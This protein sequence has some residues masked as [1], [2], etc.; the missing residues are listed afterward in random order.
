MAVKKDV[1]KEINN[2]TL[3]SVKESTQVVNEIFDVLMD[4]LQAEDEVVISGFGRF[5]LYE[6]QPRPVRNPKTQEEMVLQKYKSIK[7]K[8]STK[9]KK[10]LKAKTVT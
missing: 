7:F 10:L 1:I 4:L 6:H 8:P 2:R 9:I 5:Y 3:L